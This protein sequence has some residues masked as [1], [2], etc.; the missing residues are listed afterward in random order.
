MTLCRT[1]VIGLGEQGKRHAQK[2]AALDECRL[3]AVVD[4]VSERAAEVALGH[5]ID[6]VADYRDLNGEVDAVAIATPTASHFEIAHTLLENDID[7]L[8]EKPFTAMMD[9]A[10]QLV[11][12]AEGRSRILQVGHQERFNPAVLALADCIEKPLFIESNR[13]APYRP[14]SLDDSV[15]FDLMIHDIDLI[16]SFVRSPTVR[17]DA[18]GRKVFSNSI[19]VANARIQF[20]NG[21]VANVT[22]SR[23]SLKTERSI[24]V[25]QE[26]SYASLDLLNRSV[27]TFDK[28][29]G[30]PCK[31]PDDVEMKSLTFEES[32]SMLAQS[33]AFIAS[34]AGGPPPLVSGRT[35]MESLGTAEQISALV[36]R[37]CG[38]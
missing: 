31:S 25:F 11:A 17:V 9:E 16:H 10:S 30:R 14:R 4:P 23:I 35:A 12:L 3:V 37:E 33:R 21:C 26:Q 29:A 34:V 7:V 15:V 13:I 8:I 22:S 6:A 5:G 18:V 2:F 38:T 27:R 28:V 36:E 24:R 19:D 1:A 20:E 32:D